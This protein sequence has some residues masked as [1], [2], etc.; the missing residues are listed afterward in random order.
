MYT[1]ENSVSL[2]WNATAAAVL[3]ALTEMSNIGGNAVQVTRESVA[4]PQHGDG[5]V[6]NVTFVT[7]RSPTL[8]ERQLMSVLPYGLRVRPTPSY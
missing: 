7:P 6:W 2:A 3:Q 4:S 8:D 1:S 5:T